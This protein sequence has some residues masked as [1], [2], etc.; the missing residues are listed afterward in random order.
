MEWGPAALCPGRVLLARVGAGRVL[1]CG[2][3]G[4]VETAEVQVH[5][6]ALHGHVTGS[7]GAGREGGSSPWETWGGMSFWPKDKAGQSLQCG[8]PA[9]RGAG[10]E[11]WAQHSVTGVL[12]VWPGVLPLKATMGKILLSEKEPFFKNNNLFLVKCTGSWRKAQ[13]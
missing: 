7:W 5:L 6:A 8:C 13:A 2:W 9:E 1:E 3:W 10:G 11:L 4:L 12:L